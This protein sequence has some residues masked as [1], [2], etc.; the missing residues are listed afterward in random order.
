MA[1]QASRREF[2]TDA[3][4]A[5][6]AGATTAGRARAGAGRAQTGERHVVEMTDGLVY[7]PDD[8]TVAP[9]DTVVWE[10]VGTVGHSVTA[11]ADEIP[12][13]ADYFAS[14]GF[15]RESVARNRYRAGD[16]DSGDV[17]ER[18]SFEHTFSVEGSYE[19]FCVPHE[20]VGM[21]GTVEVRAGGA[22][23]EDGPTVPAVPDA[24]RTLVVAASV[25]F[26]AVVALAYFFLKYGGDYGTVERGG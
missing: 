18:E 11:D 16:P 1:N 12:A 25:V 22:P 4:T 26:L 5:S 3:T 19:Y 9:G 6:L 21:V 2:L 20:A 17:G 7:D 13:A 24:A 10:T 8:L 23:D 14:G 15:G